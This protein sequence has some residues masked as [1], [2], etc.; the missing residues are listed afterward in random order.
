MA[1]L[2]HISADGVIQEFSVPGVENIGSITEGSGGDLWFE[3]E[4]IN[5][6]API[7]LRMTRGGSVSA[8][9]VVG[10]YDGVQA[11]TTAPDGAL[12]FVEL[13]SPPFSSPPPSPGQSAETFID[14]INP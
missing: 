14:T 12:W 7:L 5:R 11:M 10:R 8:F 2:A 6:E 1:F 3:G 4:M 13:D 9:S